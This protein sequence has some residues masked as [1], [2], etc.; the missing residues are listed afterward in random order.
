MPLK[1]STIDKAVLAIAKLKG[2][3]DW[4]RWSINLQFAMGHTWSYLDGSLTELSDKT[5]PEHAE[6]VE[7]ENNTR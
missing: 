1:D 3:D 4:N 7:G 6:W 2:C 5:K